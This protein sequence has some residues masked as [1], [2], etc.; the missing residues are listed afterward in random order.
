[1]FLFDNIYA[2]LKDSKG[3]FPTHGNNLSCCDAYYEDNERYPV[4]V[5]TCEYVDHGELMVNHS[6][7]ILNGSVDG[8]DKPSGTVYDSL[9]AANRDFL[10]V[11]GE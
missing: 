6:I 5:F 3:G 11:T 2:V 7:E 8:Y 1:M 10:F 4:R 9:A